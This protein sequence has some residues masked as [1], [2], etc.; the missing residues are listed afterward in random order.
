MQCLLIFN[1]PDARWSFQ[2]I[3][4]FLS[5]SLHRGSLFLYEPDNT[6][7]T[8]SSPDKHVSYHAKGGKEV[9]APNRRSRVEEPQSQ[10][11]EARSRLV[12]EQVYH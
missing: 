6:T 5:S 11:P 8:E 1:F 12:N 4:F 2:E 9:K 3:T 7:K 10:R